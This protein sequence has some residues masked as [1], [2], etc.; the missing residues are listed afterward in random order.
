[1]NLPLEILQVMRGRPYTNLAFNSL[2]LGCLLG[3]SLWFIPGSGVL[4]AA[5]A[6]TL[7]LAAVTVLRLVDTMRTEGIRPLRADQLK[8]I[9][10][11]LAGVAAGALVRRADL[12]VYLVP[13]LL[14]SSVFLA[15]Y[16]LVLYGL[17]IPPEAR[18]LVRRGLARIRRGAGRSS[19]E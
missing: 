7:S 14:V 16:L 6:S 13:D 15:V 3:L 18:A 12:P 8:P 5:W 2:W 17:G 1:M 4:G 9:A 19:S 10:A 11:V